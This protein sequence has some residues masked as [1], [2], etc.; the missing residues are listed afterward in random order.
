M[1]S[2]PLPCRRPL[3]LLLL[4]LFALVPGLRAAA[5]YEGYRYE[6]LENLPILEGGRLKP[7]HTF[8]VETLQSIS[9]RATYR[10]EG[11][12]RPAMEVVLEIWSRPERWVEK[13]LVLVNYGPLREE[14]GLAKDRKRF[15]LKE[16]NDNPAVQAKIAEVRQLA[17]DPDKPKLDNAQTEMRDVDNRLR[18]LNGLL[19]GSAFT[20]VPVSGQTLPDGTPLPSSQPAGWLIPSEAPVAHSGGAGAKVAAAAQALQTAFL[21]ND[22]AAFAKASKDFSDSLKALNLMEY[23]HTSGVMKLETLYQKIHPFGWAWIAYATALIVL[24]LTTLAGRAAGYRIAWVLTVIGFAMQIAGFVARIIIGGRAPVTNMY[25]SVIWV[26]FG[27]VFFAIVMEA[28][29]RSRMIFLGALPVAVVALILADTQPTVLRSSIDP[30]APVLRDNFWLSTH[31]TSITLSYAAF[32]L[33]LGVGH[34]ILF[35]VLGNRPVSSALYNYLYRS[36]QIGVLLLATG[37]ILGAVWA[38]Y[39][40]G[41]FWDW[42]PK[43][44]WALIALLG[45]LALLHGRIAGWWKGFGLAVGSVI[46]FQ[47]VIMAWYGVNFVLGQGLHSYGFGTGGVAYVGAY[48]L[49]EFIFVGIVLIRHATLRRRGGDDADDDDGESLPS[50]ADA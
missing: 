50:P 35:K 5:P 23:P 22:A 12:K 21:S 7:F 37:T 30:L 8:A 29:Y 14:V 1:I 46:A 3:W 6:T 40:W 39:S 15:S 10:E 47:S 16:L 36:L 33:A 38:N 17:A 2:H 13:E 9:G 18:L 44:T 32:A 48:V 19:H 20:F 4:L 26:A 28:I 25:E 34:I 11:R 31:V 24:G 45:Y 43:E 42:D 27:V 49:A 41:R